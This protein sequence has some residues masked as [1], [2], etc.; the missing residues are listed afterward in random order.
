M[1]VYLQTSVLWC[2]RR[3]F[4]EAA[5][6]IAHFTQDRPTLG[7]KKCNQL[8]ERRYA[9]RPPNAIVFGGIRSDIVDSM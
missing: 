8:L 4:V 9:L 3:R 1:L 5:E 2:D 6:L 7:S